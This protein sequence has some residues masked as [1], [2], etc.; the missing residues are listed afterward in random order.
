MLNIINIR[1]MQ[2][3][4]TMRYY[5]IPTRMTK[6]KK[7]GNAKCWQVVDKLKPPWIASENCKIAWPPWRT[8]WQFL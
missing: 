4:I 1:K 3:K 8:I 2:M 6:I 5:Y 7:T